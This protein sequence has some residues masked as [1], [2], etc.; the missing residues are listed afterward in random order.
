MTRCPAQ[1][2][3]FTLIEVVVALTIL[4]W[5]LGSVLFMVSQYADERS[6]MRDR[7]Y[8][9]QVAWNRMMEN[10]QL[11]RGWMPVTMSTNIELNGEERQAGQTWIWQLDVAT[12][13]GRDLFR[14]E[15][16][17]KAEEGSATES[18]LVMYLVNQQGGQ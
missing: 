18:R 16:S 3:A 1:Q 2:K 7:F 15:A 5:V 6:M 17:I 11:S 13:L 9:N 4:G 10:Y 14:Y 8:S 12:A